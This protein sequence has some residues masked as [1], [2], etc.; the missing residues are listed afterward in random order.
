MTHAG[1]DLSAKGTAMAS[2]E[3]RGVISSPALK[4]KKNLTG[5]AIR[6]LMHQYYSTYFKDG[7]DNMAECQQLFLGGGE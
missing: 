6:D 4:K 1:T 2:L 7:S 5:E 3:D